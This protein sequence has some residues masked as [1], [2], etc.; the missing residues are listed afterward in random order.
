MLSR[1]LSQLFY[2]GEDAL[3]GLGTLDVF[4]L[5][6]FTDMKSTHA[7]THRCPTSAEANVIDAS[8][9]THRAS[10]VVFEWLESPDQPSFFTNRAKHNGGAFWL[11]VNIEPTGECA[12]CH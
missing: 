5:C 1:S 2:N 4:H 8:N 12:R 11:S 7:R 6:N 3:A 9:G 10:L